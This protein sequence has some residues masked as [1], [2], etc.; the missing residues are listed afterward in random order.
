MISLLS[1]LAT[2]LLPS[3]DTV[4]IAPAQQ[5]YP[6]L[7]A[8]ARRPAFYQAPY[9]VPDTLEGRFD[10]LSLIV[11]TL[12]LSL[13]QNQNPDLAQSTFNLM[14]Q[15]LER[16][17]REAGVGDLSVPKQMRRMIQAFYGRNSQ[18][19]E[20]LLQAEPDKQSL[21]MLLANNIY[22]GQDVSDQSTE[23]LAAWVL[24]SWWP[25]LQQHYDA[26]TI[27]RLIDNLQNRV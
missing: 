13:S 10:L 16:N 6:A 2:R 3:Q 1:R 4:P 21:V 24:E 17:L 15:H 19:A 26:N 11:G 12:C 7:A 5:L 9:D 23:A 14:F 18:Y 22:N 27:K 20:V 8:L 25:N